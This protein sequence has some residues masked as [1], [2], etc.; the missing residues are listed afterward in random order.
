M[1]SIR[2]G[3]TIWKTADWEKSNETRK[4]SNDTLEHVR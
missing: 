3:K 2:E 1:V 4:L